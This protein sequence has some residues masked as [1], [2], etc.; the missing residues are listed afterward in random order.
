MRI[1]LEKRLKTPPCAGFLNF[2]ASSFFALLFG[3]VLLKAAGHAPI[4][5]YLQM[6][7][8]AFGGGYEL[9]ETLVKATPLIIAGLAV[10]LSFRVALW[11]IGAEGQIYLGAA[12]ASF[13]ALRADVIPDFLTL[14]LMGLAAFAAGA[15]WGGIPGFL[16]AYLGVSEILTS[17][18]MN[19]IAVFF[20]DYLVYGPWKDPKGY[21]FPLTPAFLEEAHLPAFPGVRLHFGLVI[22][23]LLVFIVWFMMTRTRWGYELRVSGGNPQAARYGGVNLPGTLLLVMAL[24]GGLA[25]LAGFSEIAGIQHR[26]QHGFSPGYGYTAIIIA[27]LSRLNPF[28]TVLVSV[29]FGGLLVGS[30]QLQISTGL[31]TA[32]SYLL[33]GSLL[34]FILGGEIF[35]TYKLKILP[36]GASRE[37]GGAHDG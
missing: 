11:N 20:V 15:V 12:A 37:T 7:K 10:G 30:E 25:G 13:V 27:W 31:P 29:L 18:M 33:Q 17:L 14:P 21:G 22:G 26:L 6:L 24:S 2:I 32:F 36:D 8:G 5:A 19:Y 23:L 35:H 1:I 4:Q 3:A 28:G 16:R 34:F 9:A